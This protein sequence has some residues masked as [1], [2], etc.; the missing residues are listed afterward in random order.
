MKRRAINLEDKEPVKEALIKEDIWSENLFGANSSEM[1]LESMRAPALRTL[2][3][4]K[5]LSKN[6]SFGK[7]SKNLKLAKSMKANKFR[8]K[9]DLK[10][11]IN[12]N[13]QLHV[14]ELPQPGN[15]PQGRQV[16]VNYPTQSRQYYGNYPAPQQYSTAHRE[17]LDP[18][19]RF[20]DP[21]PQGRKRSQPFR[22]KGRGFQVSNP[23]ILQR[24]GRGRGLKDPSQ[25]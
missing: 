21:N 5:P 7:K 17:T 14:D 6:S 24:R 8:L 4:K 19:E 15:Y 20:P 9:L 11:G 22:G 2:S 18:E 10:R 23:R 12:N 3:T 16:Y 25:Q 13:N 1:V